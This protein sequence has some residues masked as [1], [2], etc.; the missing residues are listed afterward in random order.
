[1]EAIY[2]IGQQPEAIDTEAEDNEV[3]STCSSCTLSSTSSSSST[4]P[5]L[6]QILDVEGLETASR[7]RISC[8]N[9]RVCPTT[10]TT[11]FPH[12]SLKN[13]CGTESK[14]WQHILVYYDIDYLCMSLY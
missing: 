9:N 7:E 11:R 6:A 14:K 13:F 3:V 1:M 8:V 5:V 4:S 12:S 2:A 10:A